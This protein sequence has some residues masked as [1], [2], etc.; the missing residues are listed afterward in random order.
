M[1]TSGSNYEGDWKVRHLQE[2]GTDVVYGETGFKVEEGNLLNRGGGCQQA[3]SVVSVLLLLPLFRDAESDYRQ[4]L[5][6]TH[7]PNHP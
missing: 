5:P 6:P 4:K 2:E 7:P 3:K 1:S